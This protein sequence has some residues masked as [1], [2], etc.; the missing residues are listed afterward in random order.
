MA[1]N[2]QESPLGSFVHLVYL[3]LLLLLALFGAS[4]ASAVPKTRGECPLSRL[5]IAFQA[6]LTSLSAAF[7][8]SPINILGS[9]RAGG[10]VSSVESLDGKSLAAPRW[11]TDGAFATRPARVLRSRKSDVQPLG[12][13]TVEV[14]QGIKRPAVDEPESQETKAEKKAR[15]TAASSRP[16]GVHVIGLSHHNAGVEIREKLAVPEAEWNAASAKVRPF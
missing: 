6:P 1:S 5:Q 14:K 15:R 10:G 9:H 16:L 11:V 7:H 3:H 8:G 4:D 13:S 2:S 12:M